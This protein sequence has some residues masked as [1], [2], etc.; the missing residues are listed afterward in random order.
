MRNLS[1]IMIIF[2]FFIIPSAAISVSP[3]DIEWDSAVSG[4]LYRGGILTNGNYSIKAIEFSAAVHGLKDIN[5]NIVPETEVEPMV[6]IQIYKKDVLLQEIVFYPQ[7]GTYTDPDYQVRVSATGFM[8]KNDRAWVYEYY[9]PWATLSIQ[10]R[11][12]P[13]II[14][15]SVA[16]DKSSYTMYD[17]QIITA[18]VTVKNS[19]NSFAKFVDVKLNLGELK[20]KRGDESM[21][22][23]YYPRMEKGTSQTYSVILS[24]PS[25]ADTKTYT[26]ST[27]AKGLDLNDIEY[28]ANGTTTCTVSPKQSTSVTISKSVKDRIYLTDTVNVR[29]TVGNGGPTDITNIHVTDS[30]DPNFELKSNASFSWDIPVIKSGGEWGTTYSIKPLETNLAGFSI[31]QA[32]AQFT[33]YN[34]QYNEIS[35][36]VKL[37]VNGP[38]I[39]V[40]KTV[41]RTSVNLSDEVNVTVTINNIGNIATKTVNG[42]VLGALIIILK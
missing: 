40:N 35:N 6:L 5:G 37:I 34:K 24:V 16:T 36:T 25:V 23:Q 18:T 17:D 10:L 8:G 28:K 31:P 7:T 22:H 30:M 26:L 39:V 19:G 33:V 11:A 20:L 2:C 4:T 12:K 14:E 1:A 9:N 3:G 15:V 29:I 41:D 21:L 32:N 42:L 27:D 13:P 38:K